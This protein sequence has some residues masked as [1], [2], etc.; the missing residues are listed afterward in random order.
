M[1]IC[2]RPGGRILPGSWLRLSNRRCRIPLPARGFNTKLG[3]SGSSAESSPVHPYITRA[4]R[5][6]ATRIP[7]PVPRSERTDIAKWVVFLDKYLPADLRAHHTDTPEDELPNEPEQCQA[8]LQ[9]LFQARSLMNFDLLTYMGLKLGRWQAVRALVDKLLDNMEALRSKHPDLGGL[10]SNINWGETG[11]SFDEITEDKRYPTLSLSVQE[12]ANYQTLE[13]YDSYSEEPVLGAR[14]GETNLRVGTMEELWQTLGY[15]IIEAADLPP[16][17]SRAVMR[18]FYSILARLHNLGY[19]PKDVYKEAPN[20][21]EISPLRPPIIHLLTTRIMSTLTDTILEANMEKLAV[22]TGQRPS[23]QLLRSS[24]RQLGFGVW[25]ELV[26]WCCVEGGYARE[27][28]WILQHVRKRSKEWKV[29]SFANLLKI[30]GPVDRRKIDYQ[31]TWEHCGK[32][33]TSPGR[34]IAKGPFLG[35][36]ERTI[37]HEVVLAVMDGLANTVR[38]GVSFRGDSVRQVW[39]RLGLLRGI[40]QKNQ[41][42]VRSGLVNYLIMRILEAGGIVVEVKPQSLDLLLN[43]APSMATADELD[44]SLEELLRLLRKGAMPRN[45]G[46][47]L[48]L[49][50]YTLNAYAATGHISGTIDVLEKLVGTVDYNKVLMIRQSILESKYL[51]K[52]HNV[53]KTKFSFSSKLSRETSLFSGLQIPSSSL[54]VLLNLLTDSKVFSLASWMVNPRESVGPIISTGM[55]SDEV[56]SPALIHFATETKNSALLSNVLES[57]PRPLPENILHPLLDYRIANFQWKHTLELLMYL[58]HVKRILW[59]PKNVASLAAAIIRLDQP[60]DRFTQ[61][62]SQENHDQTLRQERNFIPDQMLYQFQ[63]IFQ[64]IGSPSLSHICETAKLKWQGQIDPLCYI[65]ADAFRT[66]LSA[67]VEVHGC[68]AGRELYD[69]WCMY[70]ATPRAQRIN[71]GG[72]TTLYFSSHLDPEAGGVEPY[73]KSHWHAW[74]DRKLVM[75]DLSVVR[76]IALGALS[77]QNKHEKS[78]T[79]DVAEGVTSVLDWCVGMFFDL[80]L[81]EREVDRELDGHLTRARGRIRREKDALIVNSA[82]GSD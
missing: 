66:L 13:S 26:L 39:E 14:M 45:S 37:T 31:D 64:S 67:V 16:D 28:A 70:P 1:I 56:L 32:F 2:L 51:I 60:S 21:G 46:F 35:M 23:M 18:Q 73:F 42:T 24:E 63:N 20:G 82:A 76:T 54:A 79:N 34:E 77:E 15:F 25:L 52:A 50:H 11:L 30:N 57:L 81:S 62:T 80:G 44:I 6:R 47:I 38:T 3:R 78:S 69:K 5:S 65:P 68:I 72:N 48:G 49:Y 29:A 61:F 27:A 7:C 40:L 17:E 19:I 74:R 58:R 59:E 71:S 36:G 33:A 4:S 41:L 8:I 75:P 12:E 22:S 43:V 10:P 9:L 53:R 55:Y